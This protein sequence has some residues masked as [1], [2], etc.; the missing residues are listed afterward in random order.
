MST[1]ISDSLGGRFGRLSLVTYIVVVQVLLL[2]PLAAITVGSLTTTQYVVF[3]P[4]GVTL[5]WYLRVF[6]RS[7]IL[8]SFLLSLGIATL[9]ATVADVVGLAVGVAMVRYR[10]PL[11]WLLWLIVVSSMMMP[12]VVLGFGF[13]QT[14]THLGFGSTVLGLLAGHIVL[15]TPYAV[16]LIATGIRSVDPT[17]EAAA[18]SLGASPMR[19]MRLVT[20]PLMYW[21]LVVGWALAFLVSFGDA[22]ISVF[23]NTPQVV[24]LPVR[25]FDA[26]R[27]A[28]LD[29]Q[30]TA[31]ASGLV[32][33]TMI[34][35]FVSASFVRVD[36]VIE[37]AVKVG[38]PK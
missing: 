33:V 16:T 9:A 17:L 30:L 10:S 4:V 35:L 12:A 6:D 8:D 36:R 24:T 27:Y 26:L 25:I 20:L 32:I 37:R 31:V 21:S 19:T 22:A 38:R 18:R 7:E 1:Q 15:V 14:Y 5:H 23:L 29:P 3:P 11:N 34:V 28:P 2:A 13:L